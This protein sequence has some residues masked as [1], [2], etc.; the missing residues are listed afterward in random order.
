MNRG[1]HRAPLRDSQLAF[2]IFAISLVV[3]IAFWAPVAALDIPRI[4]DEMGW[5][6]RAAGFERIYRSLLQGQ[7][8]PVDALDQAYGQ[9]KWSPLH[10]MLL[11]LGLL[12]SAG[13]V[14]GARLVVVL[15]SAATSAAVYL[16]TS[17][18]ST[19]KAAILA[20][21]I[22]TIHPS[23]IFFSHFLFSETTFL[24]LLVLSVYFSVLIPSAVSPRRQVGYALLAGSFLALAALTRPAILPL[25]I[26]IPLW[27][28][29]CL[30]KARLLMPL[31]V[32]LSCLVVLTPWEIVLVRREG[33]FMFLWANT[34]RVLYL[35]NSPGLVRQEALAVIDEYAESHSMHTEE[36]SRALLIEEI[37]GAPEAF[38]KRTIRKLP[39]L[40]AVDRY[41]VRHILQVVYPPLPYQLVAGIWVFFAVSH[42]LFTAL[43]AWGLLVKPPLGQRYLLLGM[44]VGM[45]APGLVVSARTKYNLPLLALLLPAAGH[46]LAHLRPRFRNY[47]YA[48]LLAPTLVLIFAGIYRANPRNVGLFPGPKSSYYSSLMHRVDEIAGTRSSYRDRIVL[49]FEDPSLKDRLTVDVLQDEYTAK[50]LAAIQLWQKRDEERAYIVLDIDSRTASKP[51]SL[52]LEGVGGSAVIEPIRPSAWRRWQPTGLDQVQFTWL[53]STSSA[54]PPP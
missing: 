31:V 53:E 33:R 6:N 37:T 44:V 1:E 20:G 50:P 27:L 38:L 28:F 24:F 45:A 36:A 26:L 19:R 34:Y 18:L 5:T 11:A 8:P 7:R 9:G 35:A 54:R 32:V 29:A 51:L 46:G 17:R 4:S 48:V 41:A 16:L 21:L 14:G 22:H 52:S 3:R 25:L 40:W 47:R 13:Q 30:K 39:T 23:F 43:A 2:V 12:S 10:P 15:L 42:V 49:R